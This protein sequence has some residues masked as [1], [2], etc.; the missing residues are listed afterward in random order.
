MCFGMQAGGAAYPAKFTLLVNV[1]HA[2]IKAQGSQEQFVLSNS[3]HRPVYRVMLWYSNP[4]HFLT[5]WV[6]ASISTGGI[7]QPG[8]NL[9]GEHPMWLVSGKSFLTSHRDSYTG[10]GMIDWFFDYW[11]PVFVHEV[12]YAIK[13][14]HLLATDSRFTPETQEKVQKA[15]DEAKAQLEETKKKV[16]ERARSSALLEAGD[17]EAKKKAAQ[18]E[19]DVATKKVEAAEAEK[20]TRLL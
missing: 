6:E 13:C 9:G 11:L 19:I 15:L 1:T 10:S 8:K 4:F 14:K 16:R 2:D 3:I 20:D 17:D 7:S 18:A 5:G 12:R